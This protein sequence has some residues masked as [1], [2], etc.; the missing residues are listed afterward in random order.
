MFMGKPK[1]TTFGILT[2]NE[3]IT[4]YEQVILEY[5][6]DEVKNITQQVISI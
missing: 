2:I 1:V 6:F 4:I 5:D 3:D